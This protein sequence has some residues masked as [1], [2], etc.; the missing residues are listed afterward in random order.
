[1]SDS[2]AVKNPVKFFG[3]MNKRRKDTKGP[4]LNILKT[5]IIKGI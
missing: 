3:Q 5:P 1:M 4:E 2:P